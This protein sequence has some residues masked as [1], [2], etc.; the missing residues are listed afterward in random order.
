[1]PRSPPRGIAFLF[2]T[3]GLAAGFILLGGI[4]ASQ[5]KCGATRQDFLLADGSTVVDYIDTLTQG[6]LSPGPC[7]TYFS[8]TWFI[9]FYQIAIAIVAF[10]I[11]SSGGV[12]TWRYGMIGL[13]MPVFYL[14]M[15]TANAFWYQMNNLS[16][17]KG[18][19]RAVFAGAI[20]GAVSDVGLLMT[21]GVRDEGDLP[22]TPEEE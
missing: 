13:L 5:N 22:K 1:M 12:N 10:V 15:A 20:I 7:D 2:S 14:L 4:A 8:F 18:S 3:L 19:A 11:V 21:L 6:Y 16:I 9:T 17:Y